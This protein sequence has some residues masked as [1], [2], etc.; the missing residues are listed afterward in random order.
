MCYRH[1][2]LHT[3][4]NNA[5]R[6][7]LMYPGSLILQASDLLLHIARPSDGKYFL[8]ALCVWVIRED[9]MASF[10]IYF[11]WFRREL[12]FPIASQKTSNKIPNSLVVASSCSPCYACHV[13]TTSNTLPAARNCGGTCLL[14]QICF[15]KSSTGSYH[16]L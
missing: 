3:H 10:G 12:R 4:E 8:V 5:S 2:C 11:M 1:K 9:Q 6:T 7:R 13:L 15:G 14:P 16:F